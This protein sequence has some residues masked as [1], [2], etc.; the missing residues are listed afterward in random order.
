[1]EIDG[2]R[3][4][5]LMAKCTKIDFG[6]GSAPDPAGGAY[7]TPPDPL[8]GWGGDTPS[9]YPTPLGAYEL[10]SL[11]I[12]SR[13][14]YNTLFQDRNLKNFLCMPLPRPLHTGEGETPP[15]TSPHPLGAFGAPHLALSVLGFMRPVFS[16]PIV[17]N[18]NCD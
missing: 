11:K 2:T 3:G 17:G 4:Q 1:M 10:S 8:V 18:P 13:M 16:V 7:D 14:H 9:P 15:Q 12:A 6:W 5:I